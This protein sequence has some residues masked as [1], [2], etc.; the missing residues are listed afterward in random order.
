MEE[1]ILPSKNNSKNNNNKKQTGVD[2]FIKKMEL[3]KQIVS[4]DFD[5]HPELGIAKGIYECII[6]KDFMTEEKLT[7]GERAFCLIGAVTG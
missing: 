5:Q 1:F 4:L 3:I 7:K 2:R 6:G